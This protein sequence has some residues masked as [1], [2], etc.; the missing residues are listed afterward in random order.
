MLTELQ[1]KINMKTFT[2]MFTPEIR[3]VIKAMTKYGFEVRIVGGAVRDF[4]LGKAPRDVD[5]AT[6]ADPAEIIYI[7]DSE[8]IEYDASGIVHGTVKAVFGKIKV[9]LSSITYKLRKDPGGVT[10]ERISSWEQDSKNRD[11]TV[12]SMSVDMDGHLHDYQDALKDLDNQLIRF[13]P[14]IENRIVQAPIHLLRWIKG[15]A[16]MENPK[17]L[18]KDKEL[19]QKHADLLKDIKDDKRVQLLL[20]ELLK[21]PHKDKL[22]KMMCDLNIA[23]NLDLIC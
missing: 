4:M 7:F 3:K 6:N 19:V 20:A 18:K 16:H 10:V 17:W 23:Q 9:D 2:S 12:N 21:S 8:G 22:F 11:L 15:I 5:L 1:R 14:N 13:C